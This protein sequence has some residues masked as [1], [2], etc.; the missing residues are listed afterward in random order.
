MILLITASFDY[1]LSLLFLFDLIWRQMKRRAPPLYFIHPSSLWF[2]QT[3]CQV[4]AGNTPW[5][6][7]YGGA[8]T[9]IIP[10][11][12]P[13]LQ[14]FRLSF[15]PPTKS[16][17]LVEPSDD[18]THKSGWSIYYECL[19]IL[20]THDALSTDWLF[21][22]YAGKSVM[23]P[24]RTGPESSLKSTCNRSLNCVMGGFFMS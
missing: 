5:K 6:V 13:Q 8:Q 3:S 21:V 10:D 20:F 2:E 4:P 14:C 23:K 15:S 17:R 16:I 18:H 22:L 9:R 7:F 24:K 19:S 12:S 1:F 11:V